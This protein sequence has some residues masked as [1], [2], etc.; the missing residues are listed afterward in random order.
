MNYFP[1]GPDRQAN[2]GN[3]VR[4]WDGPQDF[5]ASEQILVGPT[6][7]EYCFPPL[8]HTFIS[9]LYPPIF[10]KS[11]HHHVTTRS[12][13]YLSCPDELPAAGNSSN[14][15]ERRSITKMSRAA[16][17]IE[18]LSFPRRASSTHTEA[19]RDLLDAASE[20]SLITGSSDGRRGLQPCERR[21]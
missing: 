9:S 6:S 2:F 21:G 3:E 8:Y 11:N 20:C 13:S 14:V 17:A 18:G 5:M 1:F 16:L 19:P 12:I 7:L 10:V 4:P 15:R